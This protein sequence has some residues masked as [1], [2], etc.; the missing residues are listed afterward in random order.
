MDYAIIEYN[1]VEE[2][3]RLIHFFCFVQMTKGS[4]KQPMTF[5]EPGG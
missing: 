4:S 2:Q 3:M 5:V 1:R